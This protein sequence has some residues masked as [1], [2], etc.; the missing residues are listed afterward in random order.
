MKQAAET[1]YIVTCSASRGSEIKQMLALRGFDEILCIPYESAALLLKANPPTLAIIDL[2]GDAL[3]A[4]TLMRSTPAR[5]KS[6]VLAEAYNEALFV[7]CH[8]HGARDFIVKPVPETYLISR[9][10]R[11]LQEHRL[12]QLV[13]Q[14]DRILVEM[15]VLSAR[16]G[17]FTTSYLLK[18][19][20]KYSEEVS[21][22]TPDP[23]SLLILQLEGYQSPLPEELQNAL[24][25]D[26]A[27]ILKEYSRGVDAVGEYFLDK[28]AVVLPQT[29]LRGTKALTERL[30]E[31]LTDLEFQGPNG[32]LHLQV[33]VGMAEYNG[34]RHY[35][36]LLN[37][38]LN[39][40]QCSHRTDG[41][42]KPA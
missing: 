18:L 9:V 38:A 31:A 35:E 30:L 26:V 40:L 42:V 25:S 34:C 12:E 41:P 32:I 14:K 7:L 10:I 23:L 1:I 8:D 37:H 11:T 4:E 15:G 33:R 2:E 28:F 36:D 3:K 19:L 29:G 20:K 27:R 16:S 22:Y 21:P 13:G 6:L 5:V 17:V 39:D 24:M